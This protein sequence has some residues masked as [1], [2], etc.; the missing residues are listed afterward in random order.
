VS[1]AA[2]QLHVLLVVI[3]GISL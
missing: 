3:L 2:T 1:K